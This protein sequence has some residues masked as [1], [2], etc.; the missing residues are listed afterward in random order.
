MVRRKNNARRTGISS[1]KGQHSR[2]RVN[3][4]D[5]LSPLHRHCTDGQGIRRREQFD[6]RARVLEPAR[7][8]GAVD[9]ELGRDVRVG[10]RCH[11]THRENFGIGPGNHQPDRQTSNLNIV[12][13]SSDLAADSRV[14][15]LLGN[16]GI[17]VTV[18]T[19][20]PEHVIG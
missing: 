20:G 3:D 13:H 7:V 19:K 1:F 11:T 17:V 10:R 12:R 16:H 6:K 4:T 5:L 15:D 18:E 14:P 9:I 2:S 8:D